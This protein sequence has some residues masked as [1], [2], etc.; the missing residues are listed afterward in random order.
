[1]T[2]HHLCGLAGVGERDP[3]DDENLL[4]DRGPFRDPRGNAGQ[5]CGLRYSIAGNQ[6]NVRNRK[7]PAML[8]R[9]A[10]SRSEQDLRR[11]QQ[12]IFDDAWIDIV[13]ATDD[14][15]LRTARDKEIAIRINAA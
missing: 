12:G 7:F 9:L 10:E 5:E 4:R 2:Q 6:L 1:M 15:V 14:D 13:S 8:V 3:I 11:L